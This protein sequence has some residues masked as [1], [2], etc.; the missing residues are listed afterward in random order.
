ML[1]DH[2]FAVIDADEIAKIVVQK[3]SPGLK[4]IVLKFGTEILLPEGELDRKKLGELVFGDHECLRNLELITHPLIRAEMLRQRTA[5][6]HQNLKLAI[7][8]IPLLFETKSEDQFDAIILVSCTAEQQKARLH[9]RS[10]LAGLP[11]DEGQVEN[12]IASQISLT[13]KEQKADFIIKNDQDQKHLVSE[14]SRL[15]QWL[16]NL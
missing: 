5:L 2:A 7:Y 1:K 16:N 12:R 14:V 10:E 11:L 3:G 13:V 9:Q 15:I 6:E 4:S 8:D